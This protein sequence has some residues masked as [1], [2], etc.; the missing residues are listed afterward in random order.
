M[1]IKL[2]RH[3]QSEANLANA[4][5]GEFDYKTC[6]DSKVK[7]TLEGKEQAAQA[8]RTIGAGFL[9]DALVYCSPYMRTRQTLQHLSL[10]ASITKK[11]VYEDPRIREVDHGYDSISEQEMVRE[12]QGYFYYRFKGGES[13]ADCFDRVSGF[14]ESMSRQTK[15]KHAHKVLIVSHGMTIRCLIMRFLHLSVEQYCMM[16]NPKNA[17]IITIGYKEL[18]TAPV[19]TNGK[20]GVEGVELRNEQ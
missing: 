5:V 9:Y 10:G 15:R 19:F 1:I 4:T 17:S 18:L 13:A 7:L 16:Q 3:G 8:G 14:I 6:P 20:W 2:V 11:I 12:V